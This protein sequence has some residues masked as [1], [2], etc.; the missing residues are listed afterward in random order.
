MADL[1]FFRTLVFVVGVVAVV[2]VAWNQ[3]STAGNNKT[4]RF[5]SVEYVQKVRGPAGIELILHENGRRVSALLRDY[6]G[7]GTPRETTLR[8]SLETC[9]LALLG[10][11]NRGVVKIH[12]EITVAAFKGEIRRQIGKQWYTEGVFLKR[13]MPDSPQFVPSALRSRADSALRCLV[14]PDYGSS[15][16][17][18]GGVRPRSQGQRAAAEFRAGS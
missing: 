10:K 2:P 3:C 1:H 14:E 5:A 11:S 9:G 4:E 7:E 15:G 13:Q 16:L 8:G 12:G 18:R 17:I 6:E